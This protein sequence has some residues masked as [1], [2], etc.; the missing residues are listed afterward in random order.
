[1]WLPQVA[2]ELKTVAYI[3][4]PMEECRRR[5]KQEKK[6]LNILIIHEIYMKRPE[7]EK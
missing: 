5:K 2:E 3:T 7:G 4:T 6:A 1:M